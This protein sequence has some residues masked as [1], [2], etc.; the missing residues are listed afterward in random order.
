MNLME[1]YRSRLNDGR[2]GERDV[3][4]L[5]APLDESCFLVEQTLRE[6]NEAYKPGTLEWM[7]RNRPDE[8]AKMLALEREINKM[9]LCGDLDGLRGA[10]SNYQGLI[11]AIVKEFKILREREEQ[12]VFEFKRRSN[13]KDST[14]KERTKA[15]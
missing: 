6:M 10:L 7:K 9:A 1:K 13:W 2:Q 11:L 5:E 8:W 12:G 3:K 4:A 15:E 14:G